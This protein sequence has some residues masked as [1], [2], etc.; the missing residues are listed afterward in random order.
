MGKGWPGW[1]APANAAAEQEQT[2][3]MSNV[4]GPD[5]DSAVD[6]GIIPRIVYN[7]FQYIGAWPRGRS[8]R[9]RPC[10]PCLSQ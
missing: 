5:V 4:Q 7:I 1:E 6:R 9:R 3:F 10:A 8:W 2:D